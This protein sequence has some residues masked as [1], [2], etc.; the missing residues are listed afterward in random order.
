MRKLQKT[1]MDELKIVA[2]DVWDLMHPKILKL[3][4]NEIFMML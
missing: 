4:L 3:L 1:I 2:E